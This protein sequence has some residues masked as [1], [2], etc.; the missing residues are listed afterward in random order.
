MQIVRWVL[1]ASPT[2]LPD[3]AASSDDV[4]EKEREHIC[5]C[6]YSNS[7]EGKKRG[8]ETRRKEG[9]EKEKESYQRQEGM[10]ELLGGFCS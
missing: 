3:R 2:L 8:R 7:M 1:H 9:E 6:C 10:T 5:F 4:R